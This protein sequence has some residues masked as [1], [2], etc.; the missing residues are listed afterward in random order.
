MQQSDAM[1]AI[2]EH[3]HLACHWLVSRR[4]NHLDLVP[5]LLD[6]NSETLTVLPN[7][8]KSIEW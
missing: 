7:L 3:M 8:P 5:V 4:K 1:V 2:K 6:L